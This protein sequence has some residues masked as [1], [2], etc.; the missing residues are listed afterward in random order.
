MAQLAEQTEKERHELKQRW[1]DSESEKA[2][3]KR[4]YDSLRQHFEK[5]TTERKM[6]YEQLVIES[7]KLMVQVVMRKRWA[8]SESERAELERPGAGAIALGLW[9]C[10]LF[11]PCAT[12]GPV[13]LLFISSTLAR[14]AVG[15]R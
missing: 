14:L 9:G 3:L 15:P 2:E 10:L 4:Q 5:E 8:G 7:D 13:P 6:T 11:S 12:L 1:D